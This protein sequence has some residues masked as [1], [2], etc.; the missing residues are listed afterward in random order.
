M[1]Y[2]LVDTYK[3]YTCMYLQHIRREVSMVVY[4]SSLKQKFKQSIKKESIGTLFFAR[5]RLKQLP[6]DLGFDAKTYLS[7]KSDISA[8][9]ST[10]TN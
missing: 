9:N 8:I 6:S 4:Y 3:A 5:L 10:F 7:V 1:L 2:I